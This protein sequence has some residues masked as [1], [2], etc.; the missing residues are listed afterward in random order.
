MLK[1]KDLPKIDLESVS[2][3]V[4]KLLEENKV[5]F[6]SIEE[7]P[8][9][10]KKLSIFCND[11]YISYKDTVYVPV[12]HVDVAQSKDAKDRVIATSKLI[13][14]VYAVKNGSVSTI[15][16]L[17]NTL[18]STQVRSYY[19]LYEYALLKS[20]DLPEIPELVATGFISTRRNFLGFRKNSDKVLLV[21]KA[22][23][24]SKIL[25]KTSPELT[26]TS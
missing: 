10:I 22:M 24:A 13:P 25:V 2:L 9:I 3:E 7:A 21:L 8:R 5:Q 18:F 1:V 19:F 26:Q 11:L 17:L 20:H 16:N 6:K 4:T 14:W 23:L 12:G 15:P